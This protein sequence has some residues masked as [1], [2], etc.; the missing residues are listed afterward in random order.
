MR[1]ERLKAEEDEKEKEEGKVKRGFVEWKEEE[2]G[3]GNTDLDIFS[4]WWFR[5]KR[6]A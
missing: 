6:R 1:Y 4:G 3:G 2:E 5:W